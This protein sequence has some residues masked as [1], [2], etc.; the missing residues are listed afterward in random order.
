MSERTQLN[1]DWPWARNFRISQG[2]R[3]GDTVYVSGQVALDPQGD[4]VGGDDMTAQAR[5]VFAN[6]REV[7]AEAGAA[8][9]DVVKIVAFITDMSQYAGYAAARVEAFP[10]NIPASSTV[11]VAQ[12]VN[13]DLLVEVEAI[14]EI[15]T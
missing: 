15:T 4:L 2:V 14:A 13:P 7:L 10:N 5:Q 11:G 8:M 6:I 12:L 9:D 3:V 1:P